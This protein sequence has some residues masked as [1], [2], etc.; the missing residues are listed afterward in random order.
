MLGYQARKFFG[1]WEM[2][3]AAAGLK[4]LRRRWS[5]QR[6]LDEIR[7]HVAHRLWN[8]GVWSK[9]PQLQE[10]A[11]R[12]FGSTQAAL[13]AAGFPVAQRKPMR[14]W[15]RQTVLQAIR[16]RHR[17]GL[18]IG[19]TRR[20]DKALYTAARRMYGTWYKRWPPPASH[21]RN[22]AG[23]NSVF[24]PRFGNGTSGGFRWRRLGET[25]APCTAPANV[26]SARGGRQFAQRA[27]TCV[28]RGSGPTRPSWP[29]FA[30]G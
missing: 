3:M 8:R 10:A 20:E 22:V 17:Q 13:R 15:T 12:H 25:T 2:A 30:T 29:P 6:V 16:A 28:S 23:R 5:K 7:A 9:H 4:S 27:S 11:V 18:S 1:T 26:T 21:R 14:R 19:S 24:W